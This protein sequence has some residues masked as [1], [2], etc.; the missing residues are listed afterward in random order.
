VRGVWDGGLFIGG[1]RWEGSEKTLARCPGQC[2]A[3]KG[4][5]GERKTMTASPKSCRGNVT[6]R[7]MSVWEQCLCVVTNLCLARYLD[8]QSNIR[9]PEE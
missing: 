2:G 8:H 1:T 5:E 3:V 9:T 7:C 6:G 4:C